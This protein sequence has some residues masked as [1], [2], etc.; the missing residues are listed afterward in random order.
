MPIDL[1]SSS[2]SSIHTSREYDQVE[3]HLRLCIAV[4]PHS[5]SLLTI[6]ASEPILSE[7]A[8]SYMRNS[9]VFD[10]AQGLQDILTGFSISQDDRGELVSAAIFTEARDSVIKKRGDVPPETLPVLN[11][12]DF[13]SALLGPN[14]LNVPPSQSP[15][16]NPPK[17]EDAFSQSTTH[18]NHFLK[19]FEQVMGKNRI[20][21]LSFL[22]R[23]AA[24][25][26][27]NNQNGWDKLIPFLF[28][29]S[30]LGEYNVGFILVQDQND[31]SV[32]FSHAERLFALMD[33]FELGLFKDGSST[34]PII[35]LVFS[36]ARDETPRMQQYFRPHTTPPRFTSYDFFCEGLSS[37][38]FPL[39]KDAEPWK[40][41]LRLTPLRNILENYNVT[42]A[43]RMYPLGGETHSIMVTKSAQPPVR[44]T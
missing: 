43:K 7:A 10:M 23:G 26:G 17:L 44:S 6:S 13:M 40:A 11:I 16:P 18:F 12:A 31:E 15:L 14:V 42:G 1:S 34:V 30:L 9:Y 3:N 8:S 20:S 38:V 39:I 35:R 24:L 5:E 36:M 32:T 37:D 2:S 4:L 25:Q 28:R 22:I 27:A 33:P 19:P 21:L 41:A 29:D